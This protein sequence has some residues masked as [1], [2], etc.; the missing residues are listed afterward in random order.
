MKEMTEARERKMTER[1]N[2]LAKIDKEKER[3]E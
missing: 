2:K 1:R 3:G